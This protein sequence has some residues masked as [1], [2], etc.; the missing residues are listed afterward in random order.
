M[1]LMI[2]HIYLRTGKDNYKIQ[3]VVW[4]AK[5]HIYRAVYEKSGGAR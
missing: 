2:K 5:F 4:N 1:T 3:E